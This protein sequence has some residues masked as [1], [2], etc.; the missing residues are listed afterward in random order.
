M[1]QI[2]K[3]SLVFSLFLAFSGC[4]TIEHP[5]PVMSVEEVAINGYDVVAYF[6][7][8]KAV[9][10]QPSISYRYKSV[11]WLFSTEENRV[12]F[13]AN[14]QKYFPAFGGFCAYELANEKL[15]NSDP[16]IWYIYNDKVFLFSKDGDFFGGND[17]HKKQWYREISL[18]LPLS[19]KYWNL[20]NEPTPE[21]KQQQM[22]Q[23][24]MNGSFY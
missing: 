22:A 11:N 3:L 15:V 9:K 7:I 10:G 8:Q 6:K 18:R 4:T 24:F 1:L 14:P 23:D 16:E 2:I 20:I 5:A 12:D 21:E 19:Q 13:E 17:G